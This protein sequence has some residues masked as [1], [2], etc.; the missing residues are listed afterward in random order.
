M[1]V[2]STAAAVW[3]KVVQSGGFTRRLCGYR[4]KFY[5]RLWA[6]WKNIMVSQVKSEI[7]FCHF[8]EDSVSHATYKYPPS[9]EGG[10]PFLE[11]GQVRF[12][13]NIQERRYYDCCMACES[14]QF[15]DL[16]I[17]FREFWLLVLLISLPM[18]SS[19]SMSLFYGTYVRKPSFSTS[20][21][22]TPYA[23][24]M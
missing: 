1:P 22:V 14:D 15:A 12:I 20:I 10:E 23:V 19:A 2:S 16:L 17:T 6:V 21:R 4:T 5:V 11:T 7:K 9:W 24:E 13:E 18:M 3:S 8:P